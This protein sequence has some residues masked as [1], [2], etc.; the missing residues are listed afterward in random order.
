MPT[1]QKG[2]ITTTVVGPSTVYTADAGG[3][4]THTV[5]AALT[6]ADDYWNNKH[7]LYLTGDNAGLER[8]ITD[9][10]DLTDT[11]THEAFPNTCDA[12]D[13]YLL[14]EW[15]S[16]RNA[17]RLDVAYASTSI[18]TAE[19]KYSG[20]N[21]RLGGNEKIDKVIALIK[22][23][24]SIAKTGA[25]DSAEV[26]CTLRVYDGSSWQNYQITNLVYSNATPATDEQ[27]TVTVGDV[28]AQVSGI[29]VTSFLNTH[30]KLANAQLALLYSVVTAAAGVTI[31]W[32]V[33]AVILLVTYSTGA[34]T[35]TVAITSQ[36]YPQ[37]AKKAF[38]AI[39]KTLE[40]LQVS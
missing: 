6:Q 29:D 40:T 37:K 25:G 3:D 18:D 31:T 19:Q 39:E 16:P 33:D 32:Y 17:L 10:V 38:E 11:L 22:H 14:G 23:Y 35:T 21:I 8:L 12:G 26:T 2:G 30:D 7:I 36:T 34:G 24:I 5:D 1:L 27:L 15:V 9:F 28:N 4:T 20:Y 13:T